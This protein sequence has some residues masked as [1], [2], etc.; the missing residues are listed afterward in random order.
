MYRFGLFVLGIRH[1]RSAPFCPRQNGRTE[2]LFGTLKQHLRPWLREKGSTKTL[3]D[4]LAEFRA[5]YNF[6]R[7]HQHLDG[8]TPAMAWNGTK[9]EKGPRARP[10]YVSAWNGRLTGYLYPT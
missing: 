5:W 9:L 3:G 7:P 4:D 1:Q 6:A 8:R 2:R 10:R